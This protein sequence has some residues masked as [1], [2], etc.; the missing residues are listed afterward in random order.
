MSAER[1]ILSLQRLRRHF[2]ELI[3]WGTKKK[4]ALI[5]N[6]IQTVASATAKE[7]VILRNLEKAERELDR[8]M[9]F[10]FKEKGYVPLSHTNVEGVIRF[11]T[12]IEEKQRLE[13][14]KKALS[15]VV[16]HLRQLNELNLQLTEQA[17]EFVDSM[18]QLW[19][20]TGEDVTYGKAAI[21]FGGSTGMLDM[22]A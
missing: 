2:E 12:S 18:L 1:V 21:K 16:E 19:S 7:T 5:Q 13:E 4:E 10:F 14:E 3:D 6:D 20:G 22:K 15:A 17:L 9:V 11:S 8:S